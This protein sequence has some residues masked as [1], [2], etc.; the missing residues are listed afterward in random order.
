MFDQMI[1]WYVDSSPT[2]GEVN[3][4]YSS[5]A[6]SIVIDPLPNNSDLS[7]YASGPSAAHAYTENYNSKDFTI[8][9]LGAGKYALEA[10]LFDGTN[11]WHGVDPD[12]VEVGY[13]KTTTGVHIVMQSASIAEGKGLPVSVQPKLLV[14]ARAIE[15]ICPL[16]LDAR[17][18]VYDMLGRRRAVLHQGRLSPG[19]HDFNL[20][21]G[22][23]A[24]EYFVR[25]AAAGLTTT[26]RMTVVR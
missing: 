15:V 21:Q 1:N 3:D 19:E 24:G 16:A 23:E 14:H 8:S 7:V 11:L 17:L 6:G 5:I 10:W 26:A 2:P 20:D 18:E 25:L 13:S 22:I 9:G 12:S 4:D